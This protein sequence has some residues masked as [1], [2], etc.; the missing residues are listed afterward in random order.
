M[1]LN[2]FIT[3]L[4]LSMLVSAC[5][6][7]NY[8]PD[9]VPKPGSVNSELEGLK[10]LARMPGATAQIQIALAQQQFIAAGR[11]WDGLAYFRSYD[12]SQ[13][14]IALAMQGLMMAQVANDV[15]LLKRVSWVKD[16]LRRLDRSAKSKHPLSRLFLGIVSAAVPKRFGRSQ[17]AVKELTWVLKHPKAFP[18]SVRRGALYGLAQAY[19]KL[20]VP[21]QSKKALRQSGHKSLRSD[22]PVFFD[23]AMWTRKDGFRFTS[24]PRIDE[25]APNVFAAVGY[26][27]A[28]QIFIVTGTRV[29][30]IDAC[31][32]PENARAALRALRQKTTAPITHVIVTHAHQDHI[33]GLSAYAKKGVEVIAHHQYH[34]VA[35]RLANAP[36]IRNFWPGGWEA[37][38]PKPTRLIKERQTIVIGGRKLQLIP[39]IGSETEDAMMILDNATSTLIVGDAL[40]PFFGAP[41]VN[42]GSPQGAIETIR[43]IRK[44]AP[45]RLLHGHTPL[46]RFYTID[47]MA[48]LDNAL[49]FLVREAK[50]EIRAGRSEAQVIAKNII[51]N[52]LRNSPKA[53]LP[54]LVMRNQLIQRLFRQKQGY[55]GGERNGLEPQTRTAWT[56]ALDLLAGG[57]PT[58][59]EKTA[60]ALLRRGDLTLAFEIADFGVRRYP[61][62]RRLLTLRARVL[63]QLRL[64]YQVINPF[65][66]IIYSAI[67][68][69]EL[70]GL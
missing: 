29:I 31:S 48:G 54:Y 8:R 51:P 35:G 62:H 34:Q 25:V 12:E 15:P 36:S 58:R 59:F 33:G 2:T 69:Q 37:Q 17:L 28:D 68:G 57:S 66:F 63:G 22:R 56:Q 70:P 30:A 40:M 21:L 49:S 26:D 50:R 3:F 5:S 11:E 60:L 20:G 41:F 55:W 7:R 67:S 13:S 6:H 64:K 9:S 39:T 53:R 24:P 38:R 19:H 42:E 65:K 46:T 32:S 52:S 16:A 4:T 47:V 18:V 27:F 23:D 10:V 14:P 44:L 61:K 43:T 45:K 1:F